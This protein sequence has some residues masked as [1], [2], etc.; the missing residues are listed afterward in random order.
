MSTG[1]RINILFR[2]LEKRDYLDVIFGSMIKPEIL[3][4]KR[5]ELGLSQ[6]EVVALTKK[7][8]NQGSQQGYQKIESGKT[9][10]SKFLY[11]Y[12]KVLGLE[13]S[14][15]D[16]AVDTPKDEHAKDLALKAIKSLSERDQIDIALAILDTLREH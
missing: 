2:L 10:N 12:C 7:R 4:Q 1:S 5:K 13:I 3:K 8:F 14:E 6:E 15:V 11:Y 16:D 9:K